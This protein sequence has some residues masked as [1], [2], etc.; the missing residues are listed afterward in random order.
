MVVDARD[1]GIISR[2]R[3]WWFKLNW[4]NTTKQLHSNTPWQIT[5]TFHRTLWYLNN[6]IASQL[7]PDIHIKDWETPTVIQNNQLF[8]CLTTQAESDDGRPPPRSTNVDNETWTRW[9]QH[10]RQFPPWQYRPEY[11]TK[12]HTGEWQPVTPLQRERMMGFPDNYTNQPPADDRTRNRM[13]GN[14]WHLPTAIWLLF[15]ILLSTKVQA[16]PRTVQYTNLDKMANIWKATA[17]TWGPPTHTQP[18]HNMPQFDWQQ[19]LHWTLRHYA[20]GTKPKPIDPTIHWAIEQQQAIPNIVTVR[21]D[22]LAEINILTAEWEDITEGSYNTLPKH[23]QAAYKQPNMITQIP[24]LHYLLTTI[25][26]PHADILYNELTNGFPL[27]GDLQPGLN[28]KVRT[29]TKYIDTQSRQELHTYNKQYIIKKLHQGQLDAHWKLMADEIAE[30]VSM[31]R[32][33]GPFQQPEWWPTKAVSLPHHAHTQQLKPLPHADPVIALAFSI[34]QTGSDG[35]PKIR[36]GED[37]RR[38]G[39]NKSCNMSDQPYHHTP[40]HYLWLAQHTATSD[41]TPQQVW[42]HDHDGAY[43]QLPLNDPSLAYV[44][45]L[46]PNGPTLWLH[47]VLLFGSAASVWSYNRFGDVLTSLSRVLTATPVVHF[48]DDYGSI[49]PKQHAQSGFEAFGQLNSTLGFHMKKSKEQP[50]QT[51]RKIQGVYIRT[52]QQQLTISPCQQRIKQI[53]ATLQQA[54]DENFLQPSMAQKLAGKCA[55][56]ATQLFGRVGRAANRALYDHAFSH[57]THLSKQT[58]Q[59]ILAMLNILQHAAPR[60]TSLQPTRVQPTIIYT[61]AFYNIDGKPKR[62]S[63]LTEEDLQHAHKDLPNGWGIVVFPPN[64]TPIVTSGHIP[65]TLLQQFTSSNAFIYFLEAW[66]AVLAPVLFQPLLTTPYIQLCDN[67]ASKHAI[68]KGT[69]KHQPLNNIIGAHWTWHNRCQLHQI[70]DRVPS[71]A[72]IADPF[73][74]GDFSIANERGW[75]ILRTPHTPILQRTFKIIGDPLF[76]HTTGFSEIPGLSAFHAQL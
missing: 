7:Q 27:I 26:Y 2:P 23:C 15:L 52:D 55:F 36:R 28:W 8:H 68:I 50:P 34:E 33:D 65:P 46:T 31:G 11:L 5:Q 17:T 37:W 24:V 63:E 6:P 21:I 4:D 42:G 54:I 69:G 49:Q 38:S 22:I 72:N 10:H 47:H 56:T 1:G 43:R 67:E 14:T 70:L 51:E 45:L 76:A 75:R 59:G 62:C 74:R 73:S 3:L 66:T 64:Q 19:H 29:D 18:Q 57:H 58:K 32:M 20:D 53:T 71:K 39:H 41:D 61:D 48:V 60:I 12:H 40:D 30:E 44:L 9:E 25:D 35:K 13:L 16:I